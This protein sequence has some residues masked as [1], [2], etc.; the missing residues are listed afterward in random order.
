MA[1]AK[2]SRRFCTVPGCQNTLS[3]HNRSGVCVNHTHAPGLCRCVQCAGTGVRRADPIARAGVRSV[4]VAS[5][6]AV[7]SGGVP[8]IRISLPCEPW[9]RGQGI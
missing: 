4:T 2:R 7:T 5:H 6:I 3:K 9:L 1:D 8:T